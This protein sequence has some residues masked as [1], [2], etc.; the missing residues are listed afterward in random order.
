MLQGGF[1]PNRNGPIFTDSVTSTGNHSTPLTPPSPSRIFR[2]L[3]KGNVFSCEVDQHG[4]D[5]RGATF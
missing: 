1:V 4:G 2:G 3:R 5:R